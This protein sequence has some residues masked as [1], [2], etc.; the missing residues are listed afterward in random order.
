MLTGKGEMLKQEVK[1]INNSVYDTNI[2]EQE[3][4]LYDKMP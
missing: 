4:N 2:D 1:I 3:I